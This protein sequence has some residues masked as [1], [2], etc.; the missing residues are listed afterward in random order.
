M[1][2]NAIKNIEGFLTNLLSYF[3]FSQKSDKFS[4]W[5]IAILARSPNSK[6]ESI[7]VVFFKNKDA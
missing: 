6:K 4:T 3:T 5:N 1:V 2:V 7:L